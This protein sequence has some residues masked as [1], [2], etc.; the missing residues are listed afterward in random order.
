M[1]KSQVSA[2]RGLRLLRDR[3]RHS[4]R[5]H[6]LVTK[7][8]EPL[9]AACATAALA[10]VGAGTLQRL[11]RDVHEAVITTCGRQLAIED[12][13]VDLCAVHSEAAGD[14][15]H[16]NG[17]CGIHITVPPSQVRNVGQEPLHHDASRFLD[18]G[19]D[20][21]RRVLRR[22]APG[23]VRLVAAE[24]DLAGDRPAEGLAHAGPKMRAATFSAASDCIP[25]MTCW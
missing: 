3:G 21:V 8:R 16:P 25:L 14:L 10:R 4:V 20:R 12:Q 17:A 22:R 9:R 15:G 24:A 11:R 23:D 7:D 19:S 1:K 5:G 13:L 6:T 18:A 2:L